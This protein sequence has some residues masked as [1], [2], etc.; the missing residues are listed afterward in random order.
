MA[1]AGLFYSAQSRAGDDAADEA[2]ARNQKIKEAMEASLKWYELLPN[3]EAPAPLTPHVAMRWINASRGRD[4]QDFLVLWVHDGRPVAAASVFPFDRD[5]CHEL[6]SLSRKAE[7]VARDRS[8]TVWAP[9]SSGVEFHDVPDSP[10]PAETPVLRLAQ[11]KSLAARF[12]ATLTGWKDDESEREVLR[13]LPRPL[14][15]YDIKGATETHP[16]LRDGALFAFVQGTD[17]E[18]LLLLEVVVVDDRPRLQFAFARATSGGLEA[19]LEDQP[20]WKVKRSNDKSSR[21][22]PHFTI[23]RVLEY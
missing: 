20:V 7:L 12:T 11:M 16:E 17:P 10:V 6:C 9:E 15:R 3:A 19:R 1:V 4:A 8:R 14:Y 5:L 13:L 22:D 21:T 23:R 18:V 2:A